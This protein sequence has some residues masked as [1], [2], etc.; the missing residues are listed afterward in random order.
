MAHL[1]TIDLLGHWLGIFLTL[2]ILSF[3]YKD[4]PFYKLAEH[5]FIGVSI[6][7]VVMTQYFNVI[8]PKVIGNIFR[9]GRWWYLIGLVLAV[10]LL[11]KL[12]RKTSWMGRF[13]IA[14]VVG[15]FAGLTINGVAQGDLAGQMKGAMQPLVL[16]QIDVNRASPEELG[17]LP[18]FSPSITEKVL[19]HRE[20]EVITHLDQIERIEAL[21]AAERDLISEGR[22]D[23][24][25]IDAQ[26]TASE[27]TGIYWFGTLNQ[28]LLF[29]GLI[30]G[31][32]YFYFSTEQKGTVGRVSRAG[33]LLLMVGFGASFGYT[34]Q[35]RIALAIGRAQDVLGRDKTE[36]VAEQIG[37]GKVALVCVAIIVVG[38]VLWELK[39][40]REGESGSASSSTES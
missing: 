39:Q 21:S 14:F 34:V 30:A 24:E 31:L 38:L 23:L 37:G 28:I 7:Y 29:L 19:E 13:P 25:G 15:L 17:K 26:A 9:E 10:M 8:E 33:V 6:G 20:R 1:A 22:G 16:E 36:R 11:M 12:F 4:N 5:I 2:C 35:G 32:I 27:E 40:R 18:G 3:L